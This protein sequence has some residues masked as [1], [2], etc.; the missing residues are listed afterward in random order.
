MAEN[1]HL[2]LT[3]ST[4]WRCTEMMAISEPGGWLPLATKPT[5][6]WSWIS[7]PSVKNKFLGGFLGGSVVKKKKKKKKVL[8]TMQEAW[9]RSLTET[10]PTCWGAVKP[11]HCSCWACA[12]E[13]GSRNYWELAPQLLEPKRCTA[14]ALQQGKK[15]EKQ[16]EA[17]PLQLRS[18]P[19]LSQ[20]ERSLST[21]KDSAQPKINK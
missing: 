14:P 1:H 18:S 7:K 9:V 10:K 16:R 20:V 17:C 12:P 8:L 19:S 6:A 13:A 3:P 5:I 2:A 21:N 4:V 15:P 11:M